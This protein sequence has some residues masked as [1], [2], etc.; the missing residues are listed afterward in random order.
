[1]VVD[2]V[3]TNATLSHITNLYK[4]ALF[5]LPRYAGAD[6][7]KAHLTSRLGICPSTVPYSKRTTNAGLDYSVKCAY[8]AH[9]MLVVQTNIENRALQKAACLIMRPMHLA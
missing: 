9:P 4:V 5:A 2:D 1:M 7:P 6:N 3:E 8:P